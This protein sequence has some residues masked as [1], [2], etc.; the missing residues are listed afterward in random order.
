MWRDERHEPDPRTDNDSEH[1]GQIAASL[2]PMLP[3]RRRSGVGALLATRTFC[4]VFLPRGVG[5]TVRGGQ[6]LWLDC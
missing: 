6:P 1:Q 3:R 5:C 2:S 4:L